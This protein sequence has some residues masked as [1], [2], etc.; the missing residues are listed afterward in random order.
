MDMDVN[1]DINS[2][3]PIGMGLGASTMYQ[4]LRTTAAE[5][6]KNAPSN[7]TIAVN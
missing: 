5:Y 7:L 1:S 4:G 2:G 3:D 6:L